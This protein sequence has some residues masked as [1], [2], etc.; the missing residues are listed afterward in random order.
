MFIGISGRVD[1]SNNKYNGYDCSKNNGNYNDDDYEDNINDS[2]KDN[3]EY[4]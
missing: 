2:N 1:N 4:S 3:K